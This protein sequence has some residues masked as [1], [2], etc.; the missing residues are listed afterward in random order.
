[1]N[2]RLIA[3]L[4][5]SVSVVS[6]SSI[7]TTASF[8][9]DSRAQ[10]ENST[11]LPAITVTGEKVERSLKETAS[12]VTVLTADDIEA[13]AEAADVSD[14]LRGTP[15]VL[16]TD[17]VSAPF[18]RGIDSQGA[19]WGSGAFFGGTV[20]RARI[21]LDG[22]YLSFNEY[23]FGAASIWDVERIEVYKGPQ[24]TTQG[25][26]SI[27]GA[28]V[29]KT[30]DPTFTPEAEA[31][32]QYGNRNNRRASIAASGPLSEEVAARISADY[33]GRDTFITYTNPNFAT[34]KT[35]QD[36]ETL[37]TRLKL[38][39]LPD[40]IP[41]LEAK[42]TVFHAQSNRPTSEAAAFPYEDLNTGTASMPSW[43]VKTNAGI[44]DVNYDLGNDIELVNQFQYSEGLTKRVAQPTTNGG[45]TIDYADI[46][47]ETRVNFGTENSTLSGLAGF[48]YGHVTSED[49]LYIRGVTEYEDTKDNL[50]LFS[51]M[52]WRMTDR[53]RLTGGLRYQRDHIQRSGTS[54]FTTSILDYDETFDEVLPKVSLAYD[55]TPKVTVGGLVSKG[56][57]QGGVNL[58]FVSADYFT[59]KP[60]TVW[61]YEL[62]TRARLLND[63]LMLSGNIFFADHK[64]SQRVLP[65]Y[66][67]GVLYGSTVVN[68][69]EAKSYGMEVSADYQALDNLRLRASLGLLQ[70]E[71]SK[72]TDTVGN[73]YDGN[74]FGRAPDYMFSVGADWN[75]TPEIRLS[76][77]VRHTAG[78]HSTDENTPAYEID[79]YTIAS[80]RV[81]YEPYEGRQVFAFVDNIF[82]E[83][84]PTW[85]YDDRTAGGIVASVTE[86]RT[87]GVGVKVKF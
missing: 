41:E 69:E 8:A 61:N 87:F 80:T 45:A 5:G 22:H 43:D 38:L 15:N 73:S 21:N 62:F 74:E 51:E 49:T 83:R 4:L 76:G 84:T 32:L 60:E 57:S 68:A 3:M 55:V 56:Y 79:A 13:K 71:V 6:L 37:N 81:T 10:A 40:A 65:D 7:M 34:G 20:P 77:D 30:K 29:V 53:W 2:K 82:D 86:P 46:S 1:M 27:A 23:V 35:D 47:N 70:T 24:T 52:T 18:I 36:F 75:I 66:L 42:L 17:T 11:K 25:A 59:F 19:N 12:S 31:Q 16:Y 85:K 33:S 67:N 28:I 26:N 50:G 48:Y 64:D 9:Q 78:Y 63:R 14:I 58:S 54:S 39:V 72:F 44:F